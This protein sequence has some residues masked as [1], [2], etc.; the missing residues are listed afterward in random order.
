MVFLDQPHQAHRNGED[1]VAKRQNRAL[2]PDIDLLDQGL[3]AVGLDAHDTQKLLRF[4]WQRTETVDQFGRQR[5]AVL[6]LFGIRQTTIQAEA[7]VQV[8]NIVLGNQY[9]STDI[10]RWRPATVGDLFACFL[11]LGHGVFQHLLIQ[12]DTHLADMAGLFIA[13]QITAA[14]LVKVVASQLEARPQIVQGLQH[15]QALLG[16][17]AQRL[18][19]V[20]GQIGKGPRLRATDP[21]PDLV[22]LRQT[23]HVGPVHHQRIGRRDIDA[24]FHDGGRNQHIIFP[25][26]E[27]AHHLLQ[28]GRAHLAVADDE[29]HLRHLLAQET[30]D[31][32]QVLQARRNIIGLTATV[33][34]AQQCLAHQYRIPRCH[35]GSHRHLADARQGHLQGARDRR[36]RQGQQVHI[37]PK[38]FQLLLVLDPEVLL[39]IN[40]DKA[41][42]L[43]PDLFCEDSMGAN[44]NL[45]RAVLQTRTRLV[46]LFG[47]DHARQVTH[48]HRPAR[49]PLREGLEM[50]T[51]QK[52]G[53]ADNRHLLTAH[54]HNEGRPQCHLG[55]AETD[56]ATDQAIHRRTLAKVL[57]HIANGV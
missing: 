30:L 18:D 49:K 34:L 57:Q 44:H 19:R 10:D 9:R 24:A 25:V 38:R 20:R 23:E 12:F 11:Q 36:R 15:L 3:T 14:A 1:I 48:R 8:R 27:G 43:E 41:Q 4:L 53:R 16:R 47:C 13:Q 51:G 56:I 40:D 29:L 55:L 46:G 17:Q 7:K 54:G 39:F 31:I 45:D 5:L 52:R 21:A 28:L 2:G 26:I 35:I 6:H 50:L 37:G 32:G 42:I 22:K 33:F